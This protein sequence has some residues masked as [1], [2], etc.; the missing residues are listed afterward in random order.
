MIHEWKPISGFPG[1]YVSNYGDIWSEKTKKCLKLFT[2]KDG[3][4]IATLYC[5]GQYKKCKVHRLV[6][7]AFLSEDIDGMQI[8]HIDEN[9]SNNRLDNLEICDAAY[10]INYG[11]RNKKVSDA[12]RNNSDIR[13]KP[14]EAID[15]SGIVVMRFESMHDAERSGYNRSAIYMI[16]NSYGRLKT[17]KGFVWRYAS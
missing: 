11:N 7:L 2:D 9:P 3:Y 1:Y 13:R 17:Y 6:A 14:V 5:N 12:L 4:Q 16:C 8:N 15:K 10:N